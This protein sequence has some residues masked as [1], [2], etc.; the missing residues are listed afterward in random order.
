MERLRRGRRKAFTLYSHEGLA[1]TWRGTWPWE[2]TALFCFVFPLRRSLPLSP[3]LK[4]SGTISVH[5]N[6]HLLGSSDSSASASQVARIIGMRHHARLIFVFLV[7]TGCHHLGQAGLEFLT[8]WSTCL[9]PD[10]QVS[11]GREDARFLLYPAD[12]ALCHEVLSL[13]GVLYPCEQD[14]DQPQTHN[15][16]AGPNA[17]ACLYN[18]ENWLHPVTY[19]ESCSIARLECNGAILAH[20]NLRL[21]V[22]DPKHF[23]SEKTGR[24]QLREGWRD[25]HQPI[26]CSYKLVTVKFEVWG[27]QTRVEQFVHKHFGRPRQVNNLRPR[28]R[29]Q[30]GKCGETPSLLKIQNISWAWWHVPVVPATQ[31]AEAE[32]SLEPGRQRLQQSLN[33]SPRLE[34]HDAISAHCNLH[35]PGSSS[36][37]ASTSRVAKAQVVRDILLIGH[38]QAFAWVDEWYGGVSLLLPRLECNDA[39][40]AP[41]N[42]HLPGPSD[43]PASASQRQGSLHVGQADLEL[44]TSVDPPTSASQSAGITGMSHRTW[45]VLAFLFVIWEELNKFYTFPANENKN[46]ILEY[47]RGQVQWFTLIIPALWEAKSLALSLRLECNGMIL[48]H[49]SFH[50]LG[51]SN[52][53][54]SA[55]PVARVTDVCHHTWLIFLFLVEWGFTMLARLVSNSWPQVIHSPRPPKSF[56]LLPRLECSGTISAHCNLRL[57]GS[58]N[59]PTAASQVAEMTGTRH[60]AQ[61]IFGLALSPRLECSGAILAHCNLRILGSSDSPASASRVAGITETGFHHVDEA[62]LELLTST[63]PPAS[64]SQNMTMDDVREYEKNMHEQTNIKVCNQH[65]SPVDDIESHAQTS[66]HMTMDEVREFE[67]ATQEATN[68]KIGIF[69]PAI[70]ISSIPLLPSSVR[71]A[72]SSAPSTP[73]STDAPEFL[74]VPK[75]RPRKKS[76][77]ETLT[78]PDLEKKATLNLP[79][80]HSSD[81]PCRPKSDNIQNSLKQIAYPYHQTLEKTFCSVTQAGVQWCD[82]HGS[83]KP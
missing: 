80:M 41:C 26:M 49:C 29:D 55:S 72:P 21:P 57:P 51:S 54:A 61:L 30:P 67:R 60:R 77:P 65:S 11:P 39:I 43:S 14:Q 27:L 62:G 5:Y 50:L 82:D 38:R 6:L 2:C 52:S 25:S 4:C 3:R 71:S 22:Q 13:P 7:E 64:A 10:C 78:L 56:T 48:A 35:L 45:P 8:S 70:S 79:G 63:D 69:P 36:F 24:G 68:K 58:S 42:L 20:C 76:A 9:T 17:A 37:C 75:D 53:C 83:L 28:V 46:F 16:T 1:S 74:S 33:L 73:L 66:V 18:N 81:K 19:V 59:S 23:K 47:T 34:C 31:E 40:S 44:P 32:E 12:S 15:W